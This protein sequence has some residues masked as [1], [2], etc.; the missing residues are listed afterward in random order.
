M[1]K[2]DDMGRTHVFRAVERGDIREIRNCIEAGADLNLPDRQ[3][4]TP[5]QMAVKKNNFHAVDA[6]LNGGANVDTATKR[7]PTAIMMATNAAAVDLKIFKRL[8]KAK[9]L[10]T[11]RDSNGDYISHHWAR[12]GDTQRF[13]I[14]REAG[15]RFHEPN[16]KTGSRPIHEAV[17]TKRIERLDTLLA[18]DIDP[19][20]TTKNLETALHVACSAG[21]VDVVSRL[22]DSYVRRRNK[23]PLRTL[24]IGRTPLICA[25]EAGHI[26]VVKQLLTEGVNV[27]ETDHFRRSAIFHAASRGHADVVWAF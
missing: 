9:P 15:V 14:L 5:L 27:N 17:K 23:E 18:Y 16:D 20:Q 22:L 3:G 12:V 7:F 4:M 11:R 13:H 25:A 21:D 8:M 1:N 2:S 24:D 26:D 10:L 6:L 19:F